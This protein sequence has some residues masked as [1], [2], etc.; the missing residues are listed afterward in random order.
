MKSSL[1]GLLLLFGVMQADAQ[2]QYDMNSNCRR[3]YQE[4]LN[5]K[6]QDAGR[7]LDAETAVNPSNLLVPYLKHYTLF[8]EN[9]ISGDKTLFDRSGAAHADLMN[10][11]SS[12]PKNSPWHL[13]CRAQMSLQ[14]AL[15]RIREGNY[16][17]AALDFNRAY[18]LLTENNDFYPDFTPNQAGLALMQI[19]I[20]SIPENYQWVTRLFLLKGSVNEGISTLQQISST[21]GDVFLQQESLFLLTFTTFNLGDNEKHTR[22][23][24]STLNTPS[25]DKLVTQSPLLIYA[26]VVFAM[27]N[28]QNDRA[29]D[30]L[31]HR[32]KGKD[33]YPFYYL[34]YLTGVAKLNRL[35][36]D[37]T[38]WFLRYLL[39]YKGDAFVKSAYQRLAWAAL[40]EG[41]GKKYTDYMTSVKSRGNTQLEGDERAQQQAVSGLV[42][43]IRLLRSA[44]LFDGGYYERALA[45]LKN[46]APEKFLVEREK[47]EFIYRKARIYHEWGE[48]QHAIP[49]YQLTLNE[50]QKYPWYYAANA[51]LNL[52]LI[53]ENQKKYAEA[54][55]YYRRCLDLN[56][57]EYKTSISQKA[58]AGLNRVR[59]RTK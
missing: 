9:V 12:G 49:M 58:K 15:V 30:L 54:E 3:A 55:K 1:A 21:A 59:S 32:P 17:S 40:I 5:L 41:D 28:G 20:G 29:I 7:L 18:R 2:L 57:T 37:A 16:A 46:V 25:M 31:L 48:A 26:S 52:G 27:H 53:F 22:F 47:L 39:N 10:V 14:W 35:D 38:L 6:F 23:L 11:V 13:Y 45:E 24:E 51:A 34:D 50:G 43:D 19:L 4:I 42:P 8:L 36:K 33:Y 44:L 56:Y